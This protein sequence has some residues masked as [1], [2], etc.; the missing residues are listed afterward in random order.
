MKSAPPGT[1]SP[2]R[3]FPLTVPD[4]MGTQRRRPYG[5]L[6]ISSGGSTAQRSVKRWVR[7]GGGE[8]GSIVFS[9]FF[10]GVRSVGLREGMRGDYVVVS[11]EAMKRGRWCLGLICVCGYAWSTPVEKEGGDGNGYRQS[12][13]GTSV[14]GFV[15]D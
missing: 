5:P 13:V 3:Y 14:G 7:A 4:L 11:I 12:S 8:R 1:T 9:S 15:S 2:T 10:F 6:P